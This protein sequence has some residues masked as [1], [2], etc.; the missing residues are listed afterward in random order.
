M[1]LVGGLDLDLVRDLARLSLFRLSLD[2]LFRVRLSA[3]RLVLSR[4][5]LRLLRLRDL[6]RLWLFRSVLDFFVGVGV[7]GGGGVGV[8]AGSG[9]IGATGV[10]GALLFLSDL[11]LFSLSFSSLAL[12]L[13]LDRFFDFLDG[14]AGELAFCLIFSAG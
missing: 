14:A 3:R 7:A 11:E 4:D 10:V 8:G 6:D 12:L 13:L 9:L 5:R 1:V 2:L